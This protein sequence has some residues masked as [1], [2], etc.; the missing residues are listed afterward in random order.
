MNGL[1][2]WYILTGTSKFGGWDIGFGG[3]VVLDPRQTF[4]GEP[5]GDVVDLIYELVVASLRRSI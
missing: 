5:L 4:I 2:V 3:D 1:K